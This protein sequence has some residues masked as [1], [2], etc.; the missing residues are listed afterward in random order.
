MN[1]SPGKFKL[2]HRSKG[3]RARLLPRLSELLLSCGS[4]HQ[5]KAACVETV[6]ED[7]RSVSCI[8]NQRDICMR[9]KVILCE[10]GTGAASASCP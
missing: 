2:E 3:E 5:Q 9:S 8:L 4:P 1:T 6:F 10:N 7:L